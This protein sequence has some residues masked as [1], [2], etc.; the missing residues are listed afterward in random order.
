M[1]P[2][3]LSKEEIACESHFVQTHS[4]DESGRFQ[5]SLPLKDNI[6]HMGHSRENAEKRFFALEK[7]FLKNKEFYLTYSQFIQEYEA[8]G[9][10]SKVDITQ[11]TSRPTYY[12]PHHAVEKP[13]SITTKL[14]VVFDASAKSSTGISL[15]DTLLVGPTIQSDL[16]SIILRFREHNY[17]LT[18]D[19]AKMYRQILVKPE[20]RSLQR[21]V[22]RDSP[23]H[24]LEYFQLNTV[25]YGTASASFISTRCLKQIS[26]D[27]KISFPIESR[28]IAED[29]YIDDGLTGHDD[30]EALI[31][32]RSNLTSIFQEYGFPLRKFASNEPKVLADLGDNNSIEYVINEGQ[33]SKT[34]GI[35]WNS[36][37]D[38]FIYTSNLNLQITI[39]KRSILSAISQIFDPLGLLGPIIIQGKILI[40]KL[41]LLKISWDD[42]VPEDFREIWLNF[43]NQLSGANTFKIPRQVTSKNRVSIQLHAFSDSSLDAYGTCVYVR[44]EDAKGNIYSNLLCAKSRVAPL[45]AL[46]LPRLELCG[47]LLMSKSVKRVLKTLKC[48]ISNLFYWTDSAIVLCWLSLEPRSL[49]TFVCNRISEIQQIT[50]VNNWYHIVSSQNPADIISRGMSPVDLENNNLWWHGPPFLMKSQRFWPSG[51]HVSNFARQSNEKS[52]IPEINPK[53]FVFLSEPKPEFVIHTCSEIC[54]KFS[55]FF[56]L[57]NVVSYCFRFFHNL[58]KTRLERL[59]GPLNQIEIAQSTTRLVRLIQNEVFSEDLFD[60]KRYNNV[61]RGSKLSTLNPFVDSEGI[62]RVGGRL[63]HAN[64]KFDSKHP[65]LLPYN[66]PFTEL[67]VTHM[68]TRNLHPGSQA[69]LSFVRQQFWPLN[70]KRLVK[71]IIQRCIPCFKSNPRA[72]QAQM[73][74]LPSSRVTPSYAFFDTGVDY[75]G[76]FLLRDSKFKNRRFL[77]CY[78]CL[79]V[80]LSTK[81]VHLELATELTTQSFIAAFNRFIA[82]RGLCKNLYSDNG[83]NFIGARNE[84]ESIYGVVRDPRLQDALSRCRIQWHF[85]PSRSPHFGGL[86]E[87]AVKS[88]K[89]HLKRI[90]ND[91]PLHYEE[92]Y[93]LLVQIE[94]ILNSRPLT[95]MSD[96][97]NDLEPL[98]P[99]HFLIGRPLNMYPEVD[100]STVPSNRLSR[101]QHIQQMA[102]HFWCRWSS[103]YLHTLHQ[104]YKW[105]SRVKPSELLGSLVLLK[106]D[107][108][109][110]LQWRKGRIV[111]LH[112]GSDG[113][114]RVVSVRTDSGVVKRAITRVC[115]LPNYEQDCNLQ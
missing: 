85:I 57:I 92:F 61:K 26:L 52:Q 115:P 75:A 47:A 45:K 79:F 7:K 37:N 42:P 19:I 9:H 101:Y 113:T 36:Q 51:K 77:K 22:W 112:P 67:V 31:K 29:F 21:I 2:S 53:S 15:N 73:G 110:S 103:E 6:A 106:E 89:Q 25:T 10:M 69:T 28:I 62:L 91:T 33:S 14:R 5:I 1:P 34:L 20:Q 65:I 105:K 17:V 59:S 60:L 58:K 109:P 81:A 98:T 70:G 99:G 18:G 54:S 108:L 38:Q 44:C 23:D 88:T 35:V 24:K 8:L 39:T 48:P 43:S 49:K 84:F 11:E 13:D 68:H 80:C 55:S 95:P 97:P 50:D 56:K 111:E 40:Q 72:L 100:I 114:V 12:L 46:S 82:R 83:T 93:T 3:K 102:Q 104:R 32:V 64:I 63:R 96:D 4:R 41:W 94:A 74:N 76:P 30:L 16:F 86:W 90:I 27:K 78:I 107:N 66:H 71:K 87:A